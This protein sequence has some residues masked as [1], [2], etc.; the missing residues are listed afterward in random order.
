MGEYDPVSIDEV[1]A[2]DRLQ[3]NL[4]GRLQSESEMKAKRRYI[5]DIADRPATI[6]VGVRRG[7]FFDAVGHGKE[8]RCADQKDVCDQRRDDRGRRRGSSSAKSCLPAMEHAKSRKQWKPA[9]SKFAIQEAANTSDQTVKLLARKQ[10]AYR[11]V[12]GAASR[13]GSLRLRIF[14]R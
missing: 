7:T 2:F 3:N 11:L 6:A 5:T 9:R 4:S 8:G 10:Q 14:L 1:S 13:S 12:F